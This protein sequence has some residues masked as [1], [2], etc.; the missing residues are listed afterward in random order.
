LRRDATRRDATRSALI[1]LCVLVGACLVPH[2]SH[3]A[4]VVDDALHDPRAFGLSEAARERRELRTAFTVTFEDPRA[5]TLVT[6]SR[7]GRLHVPAARG[8]LRVPPGASLEPGCAFDGAQD[9]PQPGLPCSPSATAPPRSAQAAGDSILGWWFSRLGRLL[10][11]L[12]VPAGP[13]PAWAQTTD[14]DALYAGNYTAAPF[15]ATGIVWENTGGART[16]NNQVARADNVGPGMVS[17]GLRVWNYG[18][19]VPVADFIYGLGVRYHRSIGELGGA[20]RQRRELRRALFH[21]RREHADQ[22]L[23]ESA[24]RLLRAV[25]VARRHADAHLDRDANAHAE[26]YADGHAHRLD[27]WWSSATYVDFPPPGHFPAVWV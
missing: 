8:W 13:P 10:V 2:A 3:G 15:S 21:P 5:A 22:R 18:F 14:D 9:G 4:P 11:A 27:W 23:S 24:D 6:V 7:G 20:G 1:A 17:R 25:G 12:R 16:N 19:S 26:P